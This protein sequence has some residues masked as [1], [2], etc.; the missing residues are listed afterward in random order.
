[1]TSSQSARGAD[2]AAQE[3][4]L[5]EALGRLAA[6]LSAIAGQGP[7]RGVSVAYSGG[8][9]S[10]FLAF[11]AAQRGLT[12]ELLHAAGGHVSKEETA[13]AQERA[14]AMNLTVRLVS[15]ALPSPQALAKAG[16]ERCYVCK[17]SIYSALKKTASYPLCD[18]GNADDMHVF[19]P[20]SRAVAEL[21]VHT[22]LA[23]AGMTKAM[24]RA[25]ASQMGLSDPQQPARPCLLTRFDYGDTP[26]AG[27]LLLTEE[28]ENFL[29][30]QPELKAGFRLRWVEGTPE[31]HA[32]AQN[33]LTGEA[34]EAV[35][36]RLAAR[37]ASLSNVRVRVLERLSGWFDR[38]ENRK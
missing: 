7:V 38:P 9:D 14:E 20:G 17:R 36:E 30:A 6:C 28:A 22:P 12:V 11:F 5:S 16:R 26:D 18:G 10:R 15:A 27:R 32:S 1:M 19:R 2:S 23:Q 34:L 21:G 29:Q 4:A 33:A 31:L 3:R 37:F 24:I 8:I 13:E 25:A 35:R